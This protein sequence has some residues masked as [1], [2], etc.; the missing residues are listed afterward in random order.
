MIGYT[1]QRV[2]DARTAL[3][4]L[5]GGNRF[6]LVL[7]DIFMPGGISGLELAR[8]IRQHFPGLPVLLASG[9]SQAAAEVTRE[10]LPVIAKPFRAETLADA[11]RHCL[12][13]ARAGRLNTA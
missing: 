5:I 1:V 13:D 9:Y 2:A 10:N 12:A 11:I 3:A 4:I 7:S 6:D 8:K